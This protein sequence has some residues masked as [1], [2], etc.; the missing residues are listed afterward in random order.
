LNFR[1]LVVV[2]GQSRLSPFFEHTANR[3][4]PL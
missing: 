3:Q 1:V 2:I 4:C